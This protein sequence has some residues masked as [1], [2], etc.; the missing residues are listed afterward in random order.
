MSDQ[1]FQIIL[2]LCIGLGLSAACGFRVFLPLFV[3]SA[4][5][6]FGDV[7]LTPG[8]AWVA[9]WPA[10][11][12]FG[13]AT[14]MEIAAYYI[15]WLDNLLDTIASPAAVLAGV[16][17]TASTLGDV[18]PLIRWSLAIIAGGGLAAVVQAGSVGLRGASTATTGGTGN[19]LVSTGELIFALIFSV[20]A[21]LWPIVAVVAAIVVFLVLIRVA[22]R[23]LLRQRIIKAAI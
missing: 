22:M 4:A 1:S 17:A 11:I 15:P 20:L 23:V 16:L 14:L 5:S 3:L 12:A 21:V 18:S 7:N 9:S 8:F 6:M 19:F 10:L 2:S 13:T